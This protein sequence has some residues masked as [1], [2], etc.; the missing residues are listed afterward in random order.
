MHS[1][2]NE[3]KSD[4]FGIHYILIWAD[5]LESDPVRSSESYVL[6]GTLLD[7]RIISRLSGKYLNWVENF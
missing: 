4:L 7:E 2:I 5:Y 6:S 3:H 1:H